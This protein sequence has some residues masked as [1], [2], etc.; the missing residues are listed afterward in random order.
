MGWWLRERERD[1]IGEEEEEEEVGGWVG[2][3]FTDRRL[4][5]CREGFMFSLA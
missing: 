3:W 5:A 4:R 1:R 2:G